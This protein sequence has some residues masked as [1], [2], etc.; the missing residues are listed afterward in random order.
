MKMNISDCEA[1]LR[2]EDSILLI[3][4]SRPDGDT[5]CSAAAL[6]SALRRLGKKAGL[7]NNP[8]V[9]ETYEEFVRDYVWMD[10]PAN[11]FVVSVDTADLKMFPIGFDGSVDLA[12]DHHAS[13]PGYAK[14]N[15]I[16]GE[17]AACGEIIM[18]L[19]IALCGELSLEEANLVYAAISTDTGCF[20]YANTTP[21]TLR[22]AASAIEYGAEN[23]RL[24]K[25]LFRS[26]SYSRLKL[27]GLIYAGMRSYKDNSINVAVVTLDM[28][29][30]AGATEDDCDDLA[31]LAGK[32]K[33]NIVA[34]TVREL[35][36][37]RSKA[38]VRTNETVNAS[39]ICARFGGGGHSMAAG[40]NADM[41]PYE[42]ADAIVDVVN[43][44]MA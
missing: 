36:D 21:Q 8:E 1:V 10:I 41:G 13:N 39:N 6:C 24:N 32:V 28:M 16:Y 9:T 27:E 37:G 7:F 2:G 31:S 11:P 23:G 3:T 44:V 5:L 18:E 22:A 4:H 14:H 17:K 26:M 38:S 29:A 30:E 25:L 15:L 35:P 20:C 33:G 42:L 19:I 12:I 43:E 40:C 34:I